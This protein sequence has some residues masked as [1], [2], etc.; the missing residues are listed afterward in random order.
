MARSGEHEQFMKAALEQAESAARLG[1]VPV[2]AVVVQDGKI[3]AQAHNRRELAQD[4]MAHAEILALSRAAKILDS[5]RLSGCSLYVTLEPC[6]MCA[7]ALVNARVDHVIYGCPDPKAG[8]VRSL[9]ALCDDP[10]LNHRLQITR[11]VLAKACAEV[12]SSFFSKLRLKPKKQAEGVSWKDAPEDEEMPRAREPEAEIWSRS[13]AGDEEA[14]VKAPRVAETPP[15]KIPM[16]PRRMPNTEPKGKP[17]LMPRLVPGAR[18]TQD[19]AA[20]NPNVTLG[21]D[22]KSD[23]FVTLSDESTPGP[24]VTM[25]FERPPEDLI[26]LDD[27]PLAAPMATVGLGQ[28]PRMEPDG[29]AAKKEHAREASGRAQ[30]VARRKLEQEEAM[31]ELQ[32]EAAEASRRPPHLAQKIAPKASQKGASGRPDKTVAWGVD[33]TP[34]RDYPAPSN[35]PEAPRR[36]KKK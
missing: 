3:I 14:Q 22:P 36:P 18:P 17:S 31:K 24:S 4:P 1:E 21:F 6:P 12:L 16:A 10:R 33:P 23:G 32:Q 25:S 26:S 27:L 20:P 11:G 5:W 30:E 8:A 7:G 28:L 15:G 13:R 34:T 35:A 9:Y 19:P 29:E 2:G